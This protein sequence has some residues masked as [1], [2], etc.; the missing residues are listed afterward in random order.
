MSVLQLH[1]LNLRF[2]RWLCC[3]YCRISSLIDLGC[4]P[5]SFKI[6]HFYLYKTG[7]YPVNCH[8]VISPFTFPFLKQQLGIHILKCP[9]PWV[10]V[11]FHS[12]NIFSIYI[13]GSFIITHSFSFWGKPILK[14]LI[15]QYLKLEWVFNPYEWAN[16]IFLP[17]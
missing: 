2:A 1:Y 5:I 10:R 13:S 12:K 16:S 8:T 11:L 6:L 17:Q 14:F 9:L 4:L 3:L 7:L 15:R